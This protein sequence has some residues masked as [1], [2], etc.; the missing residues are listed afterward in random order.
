[1]LNLSLC[2]CLYS[3]VLRF[4]ACVK[5]YRFGVSRSASR[6]SA[7]IRTVGVEIPDFAWYLSAV[8]S[9]RLWLGRCESS[10]PCA[11]T[12][13]G[14]DTLDNEPLRCEYSAGTCRRVG[15]GL[16][17]LPAGTYSLLT[18]AHYQGLAS[19]PLPEHSSR[20]RFLS[21]LVESAIRFSRKQKAPENSRAK[22]WKVPENWEM[23]VFR[24][25]MLIPY[26]TV[27]IHETG[28]AGYIQQ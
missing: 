19:L 4:M 5:R 23:A 24:G 20:T 7:L 27:Q 6:R 1:M 13:S 3:I 26:T 12:Y 18:R 9:R 16:P 21:K 25:C 8:R 2:V 22:I 17:V 28:I 10:P 14:K 11:C 15:R